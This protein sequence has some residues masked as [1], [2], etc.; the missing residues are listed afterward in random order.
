MS[1]EQATNEMATLRKKVLSLEI[2]M[3][4]QRVKRDN[5]EAWEKRDREA[6]IQN[7]RRDRLLENERR[8]REAATENVG[9]RASSTWPLNNG[10]HPLI[11]CTI[12]YMV[13]IYLM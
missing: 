5:R 6:A 9:G 4:M 7:E 12:G 3:K 1:S 11:S 10:N 8:D 2:K 13:H